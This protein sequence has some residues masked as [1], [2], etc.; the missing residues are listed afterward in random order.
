MITIQIKAQ[1]NNYILHLAFSYDTRILTEIRTLPS[2]KWNAE[3][4]VWEIPVKYLDKLIDKLSKYDEI[5]IKADDMNWMKKK[6]ITVPSNFEFKTKPFQHQIEGFRYGMENDKWLLADEQGLG[7]TK[8]VIDI[9]IAKKMAKGYKHCLIICGVNGLKWNW[10][11]EVQTHSNE[12]AHILG[13]KQ[14]GTVG[15]TA[16]KLYDLAHISEIRD[17]FIITNIESLREEELVKRLV[18]LCKTKVI[19]MIAADESHRMKN[20]NSMQGK[21]FLK[22]HAETMIAMTGTPLMNNPLDFYIILKWLGYEDHSFY[23]FKNYYCEMGG[24]G[25]YQ[26]IGYKHLEDLQEQLNDF[27][28][29]RL[30]KDVLDLPEKT[31]I[32]EY[33]EMGSKQAQIYREIS[34]EIQANIDQ[35]KKA[36]NPLAEMIRM[37]QATGYT[38]ILSS[39]VKESA[40]LD[41]MEELVEEAR[42]NSKQVVIFSNWTQMT[43]AIYERLHK[44]YTLSVITGETK[45]ELRQHNVREFQEGRSE[46]IIGT[47]GAM[48][49]GLTLTSGSVE[50]FLDHPWTM[51]AYNQAV[52]RCHRIG[53]TKNITIYNL[54]TRFTI[55]EKI[56]Q[57]VKKKGK[58][59][60]FI[61]DGD[62]EFTKEQLVDYL[63]S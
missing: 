24:Y 15:G 17:Y 42:Q 7:K 41:R 14:N 35:I 23:A 5:E 31:L 58:L 57:L 53:Q 16:D 43:D 27:M 33:V 40:K 46:V 18:V 52:D 61:I 38:G 59:S 47:I 44:K 56:W 55:D 45:D 62:N 11:N 13:Q 30:K 12:T 4:K 21:G 2:K 37:R 50:I 10:Y 63:L 39:T 54:I 60:D 22:L 25:N 49:T 9:A 34:M 6:E 8:Q 29:R 48:G 1:D 32:D 51:A 20:P 19:G 3:S 26:I 36:N 28:L